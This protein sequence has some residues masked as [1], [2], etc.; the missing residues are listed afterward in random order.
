MR[1]FIV[2]LMTDF[3]KMFGKKIKYII[4]I[5]VLAVILAMGIKGFIIYLDCNSRSDLTTDDECVFYT[6]VVIINNV[7]Y[8]FMGKWY[9]DDSP[10]E[11]EIL[12]TVNSYVEDEDP[13]EN[14]QTG[15]EELLGQPYALRD[16]KL[17]VRKK[18][19]LERPVKNEDGTWSSMYYY[20]WYELEPVY[21]EDI[22]ES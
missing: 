1:G 5:L 6:P 18:K 9:L 15:V 2:N 13:T 16:G 11:D 4:I 19:Q 3:K 21:R 22:P 17:L 20:R 10:T 7:K 8:L 14:G 12:G